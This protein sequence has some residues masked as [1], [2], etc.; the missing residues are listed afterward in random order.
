MSA[1]RR[2]SRSIVAICLFSY[3]SAAFAVDPDAVTFETYDN[4]VIRA[5][6]YGQPPTETGNPMVILLHMYRSDRT[7]FKPLIEPLHQ[8]G[9]AILAIDLRG[10]GESATEQSR[11]RV[12]QTETAIF[13]DM[14]ND[15]RAAYSWLARQKGIDRSRF[16]LVGAS[17]G[18]S[19]A[20]DYAVHDRSVDAIVCL[21]PGENYLGLDSREDIKQIEGCKLWLI[22][23]ANEKE[24]KAI[25]TLGSLA[26]S[27][28]T[29]LIDGDFHGTHMFGKVPEIEKH[30]ATFLKKNVGQPTDTTVY[31]SINSDIYHLAGSGWIDRI[32]PGNLRHYSSPAEAEARGLRIAKNRGPND[33]SKR[34]S[35]P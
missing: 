7:A 23:A 19:V 1:R 27:A 8:A 32:S 20:L 16:A 26:P 9:F 35:K 30:I 4:E 2:T 3:T 25:K 28:K 15:V 13:K 18:C 22:G 12:L 11:Q 10:H 34:R 29:D 21:S 5:D 33:K 14:Y 6:Y 24:K 17:V 31:G